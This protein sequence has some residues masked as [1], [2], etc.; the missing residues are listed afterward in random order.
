MANQAAPSTSTAQEPDE[1]TREE[2]LTILRDFNP[3][4]DRS[5]IRAAIGRRTNKACEWL[6]HDQ[7]YQAWVKRDTDRLW[8]SGSTGIGKT[9]LSL[10]VTERLEKNKDNSKV[11]YFFCSGQ[12]S[13]RSSAF[14]IIRSWL[15]QLLYQTPGLP[16]NI[17]TI[18]SKPIQ[19]LEA[20]RQ[21]RI[22]WNAFRFI[23]RDHS[24]GITYCVFD[25]LH[26]CDITTKATML[27]LI[28][29]HFPH[30]C[31][32]GERNKC[33]LLITSEDDKPPSGFISINLEKE[34]KSGIQKDLEILL[35]DRLTK[36]V[37]LHHDT[38]PGITVQRFRALLLRY[39]SGGTNHLLATLMLDWQKVEGDAVFWFMLH[40]VY[41]SEPGI[42][43]K[44]ETIESVV[45]KLA[46]GQ[47][48][49]QDHLTEGFDRGSLRSRDPNQEL[50]LFYQHILESVQEDL[51]K[52][53]YLLLRLLCTA[54]SPLTAEDLVHIMLPDM[55]PISLAVE[56]ETDNT[57]SRDE[58][59]HATNLKPTDDAEYRNQKGK[60]VAS[61]DSKATLAMK[62]FDNIL[63]SCYPLIRRQKSSESD[64]TELV[65][66]HYSVREYLVSNNNDRLPSQI[67][68]HLE[69][70]HVLLAKA[71]IN[72]I[73]NQNATNPSA[74]LWKKGSQHVPPFLQYAVQN[75]FK[76]VKLLGSSS[77]GLYDLERFLFRDQNDLRRWWRTWIRDR[78]GLLPNQVEMIPVTSPT[79]IY[80]GFGLTHWLKRHVRELRGSDRQIREAHLKWPDLRYHSP[81]TWALREGQ[82]DTVE[83]LCQNGVK[84]NQYDLPHAVLA[85][86]SFFCSVLD[87]LQPITP[88]MD[89][90]LSVFRA[91]I[92]LRR[93]EIIHHI[94]NSH[95]ILGED[96]HTLSNDSLQKAVEY[97]H[98]DLFQTLLKHSI[99]GVDLERLLPRAASMVE[100]G[101][102][103]D[104][105]SQEPWKSLAD[106]SM[107]M[108]DALNSAIYARCPLLVDSLMEKTNII[109]E[110][111]QGYRA[112]EAAIYAKDITVMHRL[113]TKR[114][115]KPKRMDQHGGKEDDDALSVAIECGSLELTKALVGTSTSI[116][117]LGCYTALHRAAEHGQTDI[118]KYLIAPPGLPEL[119]S[120]TPLILAA[121]GGHVDIVQELLARGAD[122]GIVDGEGRT[123]LTWA[124]K[125]KRK[126][127]VEILEAHEVKQAVSGGN[128]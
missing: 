105:L 70:T 112:F 81:L 108:A 100:E 99:P 68:L 27:D 53:C 20:C 61:D 14:A 52:D 19:L 124:K 7:K 59:S 41:G 31:P 26:E 23:L 33:K 60:S 55:D 76:H 65:F 58:E 79:H 89:G 30:R 83:W 120:K 116:G 32:S 69:N 10:F 71:C 67:G 98:R 93:P 40:Q 103:L 117:Q 45:E 66:V 72:A 84:L 94:L 57:E 12:D 17:V 34:H 122:T 96:L 36:E 118:A 87:L 56:R 64:K 9:A 121:Q 110:D 47:H 85:G 37:L 95:T 3:D 73:C 86:L 15:Y 82:L 2:C 97:G 4:D 125:K 92:R 127:V 38:H 5:R 8:I 113:I 28:S 90:F 46:E 51:Q 18:F 43:E 74:Y 88:D 42:K 62:T 77:D 39:T 24:S 109:C 49:L 102:A 119:I 115:Y 29:S 63:E 114:N 111:P 13:N 44:S 48:I 16:R 50:E 107:D 80:A 75:W 126:R 128:K 35:E 1:P 123:A 25:G 21:P 91:A 22:L 106:T 6:L 78:Y 104:M 101:I 11:L 54:A